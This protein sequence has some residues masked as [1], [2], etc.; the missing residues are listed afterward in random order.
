MKRMKILIIITLLTLKAFCPSDEAIRIVK[1]EPIQPFKQLIYAIGSV[2]CSFDTLAYN[3]QEEATG[4]FQIRPIRIDDYR[5]RTGSDY[6]LNDMYDYYKAEKVFLYYASQIG[7]YDIERVIRNWNG[8]WSLTD[9][10][11]NK[12]K[13]KL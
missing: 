6:T 7:P 10:Y 13:S 4:Y 1:T 3:A 8:K 11:Y 9:D 12:V 2:E 5:K